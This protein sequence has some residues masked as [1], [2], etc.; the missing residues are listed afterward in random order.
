MIL[1]RSRM[2][3]ETQQ[4]G[5]VSIFSALIIMAVVGLIIIG[6][7]Y[8][9]QQATRRTTDDQLN[10]QAYYAAES[11]INYVLSNIATYMSTPSTDCISGEVDA[12]TGSSFTCVLVDPEPT[13]LRY[14]SVPIAGGGQPI[15]ANVE[16]DEAVGYF[17]F[18]FD[19]ADD[20]SVDIPDTGFSGSQ[21]EFPNMATWDTDIG[22]LRLDVV[23]V[24][25]LTR[26]SLVN[27]S[28]T[29][30]LYPSTSG[31]GNFTVVSGQQTQGDVLLTSCPG[32]STHRCVARVALSGSGAGRQ[33]Y[34][35]RLQSLYNPLQV[36][37]R[38]LNASRSVLNINNGQVVIDST[39]RATDVYK[40]VQARIP[41][42]GVGGFN[43]GSVSQAAISAISAICKR[44]E[45]VPSNTSVR[46]PGLSATSS[47]E[48]CG[49]N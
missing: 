43:D 32:G 2:S 12:A 4:D 25:D 34:R 16:V 27:N 17:E 1:L 7:T 10:T 18:E 40:R 6:F 8:S 15:V 30:F 46:N 38:P 24:D 5:F 39:G 11:G 29:F 20:T 48:Y 47:V 45:G 13:D 42:S 22:V 23:P 9:T 31:S 36:T 41:L 49:F 33:H 44:Y 37:L 28:Y 26:S 3:S 14:S 21:P 19:D 35:V